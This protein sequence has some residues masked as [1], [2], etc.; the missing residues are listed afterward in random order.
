MEI[1]LIVFFACT[2]QTF[3][4]LVLLVFV[5]LSHS[6]ISLS[7]PRGKFMDIPNNLLVVRW[8]KLTIRASSHWTCPR[9]SGNYRTISRR[10]LV[11]VP[12]AGFTFKL[13]SDR[14][15]IGMA[16]QQRPYSFCSRIDVVQLRLT[17]TIDP[18]VAQLDSNLKSL[19]LLWAVPSAPPQT[20]ILPRDVVDLLP[21]LLPGVI[22]RTR[23][24]V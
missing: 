4:R 13:A 10:S 23:C 9:K 17:P 21:L 16:W 19:L 18:T 8:P 2:L 14:R 20:I 6:F 22:M 7:N 5:S 15:R 12:S 24:Y 11:T 3:S 1:W